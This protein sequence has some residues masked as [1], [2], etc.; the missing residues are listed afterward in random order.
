M[1]LFTYYNS[2]SKSVKVDNSYNFQQGDTITAFLYIGLASSLFG[3][4]DV[5]LKLKVIKRSNLFGNFL[6]FASSVITKTKPI[7]SLN[8]EIVD[9]NSEEFKVGEKKIIQLYTNVY[10]GQNIEVIK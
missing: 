4:P 8:C 1:G 3:K 10:G 6:L 7:I 2:A 5:Y 9:S